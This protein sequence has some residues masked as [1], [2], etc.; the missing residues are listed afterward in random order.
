M[1]GV[2]HRK[3]VMGHG[4]SQGSIQVLGDVA[5]ILCGYI[6]SKNTSL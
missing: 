1:K 5:L 6:V 4:I 2:I 3:K